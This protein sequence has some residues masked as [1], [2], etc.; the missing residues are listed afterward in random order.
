MSLT[1]EAGYIYVYSKELT[2]VNKQLKQLSKKAEKH[3]HKHGKTSDERKKLKH[4]KKHLDT[5]DEIK[6]LMKR[7]NDVLSSIKY[8]YRAYHH[9]LHK[10][11]KIK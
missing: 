8:H 6:K 10:E 1:K 9:A 7:H 3:A 5:T 11:H 2:K 4:K